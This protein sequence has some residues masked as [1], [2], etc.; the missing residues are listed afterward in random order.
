[1][2]PVSVG[3][4]L[5]AVAALASLVTPCMAV[6]AQE[7]RAPGPGPQTCAVRTS[8]A[9]MALSVRR[10]LTRASSVLATAQCQGIFQEFS[11]QA[12]RPLSRYTFAVTQPGSRIV[13]VCAT[14]FTKLSG[15]EP[16]SGRRR[17]HPRAAAC[18]RPRRKSAHEL[19]DYR[20][21]AH[22]VCPLMAHPT[23]AWGTGL[24]KAGARTCL[25]RDLQGAYALP[26]CVASSSWRG[27]C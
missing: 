3:N 26:R 13:L 9:V 21:G 4:A 7:P 10:A 25:E 16:A 11:D 12:G 27:A 22:A 2:H 14:Q 15:R 1:M 18:S 23:A 17:A 8:N 5:R 24:G 19:G 20:A 6:A